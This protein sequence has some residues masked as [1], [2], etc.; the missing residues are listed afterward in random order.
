MMYAIEAENLHKSYDGLTVL[1]GLNLRVREGQVYG[2][3]GPNGSG[4]STLLHLLLGFLR[5]SQ[6]D[7]RISGD[8]DLERARGRIGYLPERLRYHLRYSAREYL[9]YLGRFSDL[10][11]PDLS[12]RIEQEL[13]A[14]RLDDAADRMLSTY[15]KGMLQRLG[16]AQA[17]LSD[18]EILLI[19]EPTAGLDPAGQREVLDLLAELRSRNRTI[20][21]TTHFLDEIDLLC[22]TVGIL[23]GGRIAAEF[24]VQSLRVPGRSV[25]IGVD[26]LDDELAARLQALPGVRCKG[27]EITLQPNTAALQ[28]Q[29]LG[30][31]LQAGVAVI[32]LAPQGRPLEDI[33]MRVVRGEQVELPAGEPS[34]GQFAPPGHPDALA[35][36]P[37]TPATVE[38]PAEGPAEPPAPGWGRPSSGDTL[39]RELL[40]GEADVAGER[41]R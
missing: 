19:D 28:A 7:L 13:A 17:L 30:M 39:L 29:V 15:S 4:K 36:A 40:G 31:L 33:Y 37:R 8:R 20:L 14:V 16:I 24:E 21:L 25:L 35:A 2:L 38:L 27:R 6:G 32:S 22:D 41:D 9:R 10:A 11:E 18:P 12:R 26:R 34:P 23:F 3:L 5:P 1:R